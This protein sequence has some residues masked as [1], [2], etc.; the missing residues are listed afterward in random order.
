VV[1]L[2]LVIAMWAAYA[3]VQ[4]ASI[5][6]KLSTQ[7]ADLH[8]QNAALAAE[9]NGYHK[10]VQSMS[11][12]AADEEEARISGYARSAEHLYLVIAAPSPTPVTPAASPA[13]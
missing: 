13:P 11:S 12:G 9:N 1:A 6:H 2:V 7:V 8:R 3:F 4:E 5:G 10:D